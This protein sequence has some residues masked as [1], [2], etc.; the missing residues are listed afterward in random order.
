MNKNYENWVK[1]SKQEHFIFYC[2]KEVFFYKKF[3]EMYN[4]T[5]YSLSMLGFCVF[6]HIFFNFHYYLL[7]LLILYSYDLWDRRYLTNEI[8][9]NMILRFRNYETN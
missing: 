7:I 8:K 9:Q 5:M 6:G 3:C 4:P 2:E 1:N